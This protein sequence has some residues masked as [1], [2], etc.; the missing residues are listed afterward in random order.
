[1]D[2]IGIV[3]EETADL[4]PE[5]VA[6]HQIATVPVILNWPDIEKLPGENTFQKMMELER[7]GIKSFGKTSQPSPKD[8]LAKYLYQI[9]R[10]NKVLCITLTSRLSG[11]YNSAVLAKT[12]LASEEQG[13]VFIVDS[14]N[15]SCG[16]ALVV[17]KAIDL[18]SSEK[19]VEEIV[20]GL[21]EFVPQVHA[22]VMFE[23]PKWLEASG[24]ISHIVANVMRGMAKMGIRPLLTFKKGALV[25]AGLRTKARDTA[26][27]LFRQLEK[28][29]EMVRKTGGRIR[30]AITHGDTPEEAQRLREMAEK[31]LE[32]IEVAFISIINDVVGSVT[33]PNTLSFAWCEI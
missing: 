25:P 26:G 4:L 3:T 16:Q 19:G 13:K 23:D 15:A 27:V 10:F 31:E 1:M 14:L 11:S 24:R 30:I 9:E 29:T 8:F 7:R 18:V 2:S 22:F 28:D 20:K 5:M 33:G 6:E 12:L 17:L 32:N 21:E